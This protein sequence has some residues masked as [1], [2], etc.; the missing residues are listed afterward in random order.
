MACIQDSHIAPG[1]KI[2]T[3]GDLAGRAAHPGGGAENCGF[4][5]PAMRK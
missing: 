5:M 1:A 2:P 3:F 4:G